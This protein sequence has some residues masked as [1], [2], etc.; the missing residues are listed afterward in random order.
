MQTLARTEP[1]VLCAFCARRCARRA[2]VTQL[3]PTRHTS[4]WRPNVGR[5]PIQSLSL[6]SDK[7]AA[8]VLGPVTSS[9][10]FGTAAALA[11][12]SCSGIVACAK[13]V[14]PG[15][16]VSVQE[17]CAAWGSWVAGNG[18]A[19]AGTKVRRLTDR[20]NEHLR[21]WTQGTFIH[22]YAI[23]MLVD[24][25]SVCE[26]MCSFEL[27]VLIRARCVMCC[28]FWGR[29]TFS[30]QLLLRACCRQCWRGHAETQRI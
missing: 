1:A 16:S 20:V 8:N 24:E 17:V 22:N 5:Q 26:D 25:G 9:Q 28:A 27:H 29:K 4:A 3:V 2:G 30:H 14:S 10:S 19:A 18:D 11:S 13:H 6:Q 7:R 23:I 15:R 12:P 21:L